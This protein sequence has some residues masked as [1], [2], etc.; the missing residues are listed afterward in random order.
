MPPSQTTGNVCALYVICRNELA[1]ISTLNNHALISHSSVL[2]SHPQEIC[3]SRTRQIPHFLA[4][5]IKMKFIVIRSVVIFQF[6]TTYALF[7]NY[8]NSA[9]KNSVITETT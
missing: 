2:K 5:I 4:E 3:H 1:V 8:T 9:K 6:I 7:S